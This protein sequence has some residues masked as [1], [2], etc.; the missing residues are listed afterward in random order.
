MAA[1]SRAEDQ[2]PLHPLEFRILMSLMAGPSFG[3]RIVDEVE[4][5]EAGRM[6]LY[7]ANLYRR[8]RDLVGRGLLETAPSPEGADPR[9][10]YLRLTRF[11]RSVARA[12][13]ARMRELVEDA[14]RMRLLPEGTG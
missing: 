6:R 3:S 4:A 12:E 14:A 10:T 8:I 7:P 5:R 13:A 11:G 9:R 2:L 1:T